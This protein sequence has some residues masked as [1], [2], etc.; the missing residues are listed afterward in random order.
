MKPFGCTGSSFSPARIPA[1][2]RP[3]PR[4]RVPPSASSRSIWRETTTTSLRSPDWSLS[5]RRLFPRR[6]RGRTPATGAGTWPGPPPDRTWSTQ[7]ERKRERRAGRVSTA[8]SPPWTRRMRT[9]SR[10]SSAPA[11]TRRVRR[12]RSQPAW[13]FRG[14]PARSCSDASWA[15][16]RAPPSSTSWSRCSRRRSRTEPRRFRSEGRWRRGG[17]APQR[18]S[19]EWATRPTCSTSS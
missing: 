16:A 10:R 5:R 6:S 12:R 15:S 3:C 19:S 11:P 7:W 4:P 13:T 18:G 2:S 8:M 14:Y 1:R 17:R 9:R